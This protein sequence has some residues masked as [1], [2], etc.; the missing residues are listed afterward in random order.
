M[1]RHDDDGHVAIHQVVCLRARREIIGRKLQS[2]ADP[3]RRRSIEHVAV[4]AGN[5]VKPIILG[6]PCGPECSL[7]RGLCHH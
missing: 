5:F 7:C 1:A 6:I 4:Y 2:P 3:L